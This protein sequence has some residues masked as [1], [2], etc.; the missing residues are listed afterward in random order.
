[1]KKREAYEL[2]G[3]RLRQKAVDA[4]ASYYHLRDFADV[5]EAEI[6]IGL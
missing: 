3:R 2:L 1:M 6:T 4:G 5:Y